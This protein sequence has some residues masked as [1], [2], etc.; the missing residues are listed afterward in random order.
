VAEPFRVDFADPDYEFRS[1]RHGI[2]ASPAGRFVVV[3]GQYRSESY[4]FGV[5]GRQIGDR[6]VACTPAPK[7]GCREQTVSKRG[8]FRFRDSAIE[9]SRRLTWRWVKGQEVTTQALGDPRADNSIAMCVYDASAAAQPLMDLRVPAGGGCTK[10]PCWI[11]AGSGTP[12]RFDYFDSARFVGGLE[13]IRL[14]VK[15]E[16]QGRLS[17]LARKSSTCPTPRSRRR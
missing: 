5:D 16:G 9:S 15:P 7:T 6:P 2:A 10:I 3:W 1:S 12:L 14:H 11:Q 13:L 17:V 8:A 4:T